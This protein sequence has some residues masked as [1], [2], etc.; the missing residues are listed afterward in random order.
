MS[1]S[2]SGTRITWPKCAALTGLF[3]VGVLGAA[4]RKSVSAP[5]PMGPPEVAT[6][7]LRYERAV[8]T[9]ELP[10]RTSAYLHAQFSAGSLP[11]SANTFRPLIQ[12]AP[13]AVSVGE[14]FVS[15]LLHYLSPL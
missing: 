2:E 3:L 8:L 12:N 15:A 10:G 6:V 1:T 13:I 7:T 11:I 5:P 14:D 9:T 4:C